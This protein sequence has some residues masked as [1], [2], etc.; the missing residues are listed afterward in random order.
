MMP[1]A[2]GLGA[3]DSSVRAPM[4]VA[5]IGGLITSTVLSL[6]PQDGIHTPRHKKEKPFTRKSPIGFYRRVLACV[7]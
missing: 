1:I 6:L 5:V 7:L 2:L 4:S 3:A